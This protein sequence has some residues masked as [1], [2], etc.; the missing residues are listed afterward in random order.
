MK[1]DPFPS[2]LV[3]AFYV[4]K[5]QS[6]VGQRRLPSDRRRQKSVEGVDRPSSSARRLHYTALRFVKVF[7]KRIF[8][9]I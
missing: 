4:G 9:L 8:D 7:I 5:R 3:A 2:L 6:D 1:D